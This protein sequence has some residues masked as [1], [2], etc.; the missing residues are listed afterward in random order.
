MTVT[1]RFARTG[2]AGAWRDL[3]RGER[4][5]L[6]GMAVTVL[7]LNIIGWGVLF[8]FVVPGHYTVHGS[9]F[10]VGLG[11]TA[12]T[13]G[14]RHAF[15]ADHIAAIDN[16]TRKLVAENKKPMSVGFWF[17]LGHSTIVFVL[18]ALLAFGVQE[19]AAS[20]SDDNSDLERW[21]GLFGTLV[22]GTFLLLIGLL[23]LMSLIAIHRVFRE[24]RRGAYDEARLERE[25]DNRGALNRVL[26]PVVAA[27]RA[28]WHMYPVGLLFGMGFD[29]VTEVGLLVIAGGAAATGLPWYS[30]LVLP[31]LFCA[32][33]SLFDSIDG[34]FMNFAYGWAL[35]RPLRKIY[36]N[37]VV[38]GLSVVVAMLIGAQEIISILTAKFDITDGVLGWIGGLDLGAMGFIIVGLFVGTW[39]TAVLVWQYG[40]VQARWESGLAAAVPPE[41]TAAVPPERAA[42]PET[43]ASAE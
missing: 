41:R 40:G 12:Y 38:T 22:S 4:H 32:G 42:A 17:S 14:M 26:K 33:M 31:I 35:A 5:S 30:I 36:Y 28:P 21:T 2:L 18:V 37:L 3:D 15:D 23:N 29:T 8:A 16:T 7:A 1:S 11:V 27:V 25:L 43:A 39:L 20:L 19:L 10:G 13:L 6:V 34:S 24:M 9:A